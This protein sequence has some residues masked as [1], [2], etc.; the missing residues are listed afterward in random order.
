LLESEEG[1]LREV[2]G[3]TAIDRFLTRQRSKNGFSTYQVWSLVVLESWLRHHPA[4]LDEAR[5]EREDMAAFH[6][7]TKRLSNKKLLARRMNNDTFLV[8]EEVL[9]DSV[10]REA[11]AGND[12]FDAPDYSAMP[13]WGGWRGLRGN[14]LA[15]LR[16]ARLRIADL[17]VGVT[18][19]RL[20]L[21]Q[22]SDL[23]IREVEYPHPYMS[24]ATLVRITIQPK[25][26]LQRL[27]TFLCLWVKAVARLNWKR[28][29]LIIKR[30]LAKTLPR[31]RMLQLGHLCDGQFDQDQEMS[32]RYLLFEG[33]SQLPPLP[34]SHV[35]ISE[36][37]EGRYS[38]WNGEVM[39][40]PTRFRRLLTHS[41]W[42]VKHS[43]G[44]ER[45]LEYV[46]T[47]IP[48]RAVDGL[49][50]ALD[51]LQRDA[52]RERRA[53]GDGGPILLFTHGLPA[54][55]AER[56]WCY[57]ATGLKQ[58]GEDVVFLSMEDLIGPNGHYL[59]LLTNG[60][61]KVMELR[62]QPTPSL[63]HLGRF[64][65]SNIM[66]VLVGREHPFNE[67]ELFRLIALLHS[68]KPKAVIAQLDYPNLLA[69]TAASI[70]GISR[71]ILSFRNYNPTHFA[72]LRND[73]FQRYYQALVNSPQI[74]LTGNA[75]AANADYAEWIGVAPERVHWIPN[76]VDSESIK[77]PSQ[78]EIQR[79]RHTLRISPGKPLILGVFRLSEEKRPFVFVDVCARIAQEVTDLRVLVAGVG[80]LQRDMQDYIEKLGLER[81]I[82][83]LGRREDVPAL[84]SCA[85]L[86]L[87]TSSFEGMP[88]V[89]MEAQ[90]LGLPVV[91]TKAGG[92]S[93]CIQEGHTGFLLPVDDVGGLAKACIAVLGSP[94]FSDTIG[95]AAKEGMTT[96]FSRDAMVARYLQLVQEGAS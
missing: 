53:E 41:Y 25:T 18:I 66:E 32:H 91:A 6:A 15:A 39:F 31:G 26:L 13:D 16:G 7:S 34:M 64:V 94:G 54:G 59:P 35:D 52:K 87:L 72:Y 70:C 9:E 46:C 65:S 19:D 88:N 14:E 83:L 75:R 56:Q 90:L 96:M 86:L 50:I 78:E 95:K 27:S 12:V 11:K 8:A 62:K 5:R 48:P 29:I 44:I 84:M 49:A 1:R 43:A 71:T 69:A 17:N 57:L 82:T 45:H 3:R 60:N 61:V 85:S 38:V 23:G 68:L 51:M 55:G 73:W 77:T 30:V 21:R 80:P 81:H 10:P 58:R 40:A 2:L 42:V 93:D 36:R 20:A 22:L 67:W 79:I 76:A 74:R 33:L 4:R 63:A 24:P 28:R 89:V 37:G 92:T 47:L